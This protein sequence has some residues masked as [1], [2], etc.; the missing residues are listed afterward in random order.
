MFDYNIEEPFGVFLAAGSSVIWALSWIMNQKDKRDGQKKLF[1][2]FFFGLIYITVTIPFFS[3]F[4]FPDRNGMAALLYVGLFEMGITFFIWLKALHLTD[5]N[6]RISN[7]I[8]L[9]PFLALIFIRLVLKE[10]IFNTTLFGLAMI[11][12]GIFIQQYKRKR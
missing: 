12:A 10:E 7:L 3:E 1:W 6:D 9:S 5:R 2:A 11:V 4:E 8:F